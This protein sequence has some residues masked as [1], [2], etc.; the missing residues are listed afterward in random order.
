MEPNRSNN[1]NY[2]Y[3]YTINTNRIDFTKFLKVFDLYKLVNIVKNIPWEQYTYNGPSSLI[4]SGYDDNT[5][6]FTHRLVN[7]NISA[8]SNSIPYHFFGG[9]VYYILNNTY[10]EIDIYNYTD[11]TGD[12]DIRTVFPIINT[13]NLYEE[14]DTDTIYFYAY[15]SDGSFSGLVENYLTWIIDHFVSGILEEYPSNNKIFNNLVEFE[16]PDYDETEAGVIMMKR[17]IHNLKKLYVTALKERSMIKIQLSAKGKHMKDF[18]HIL[19]F[20]FVANFHDNLSADVTTGND[21]INDIELASMDNGRSSRNNITV[22]NNTNIQSINKLID[23]NINAMVDR[24][25]VV[26]TNDYIH[27]HKFYNHIGRLQ[28]LNKL[29]PILIG[30][31]IFNSSDLYGNRLIDLLAELLLFFDKDIKIL[32]KYIYKGSLLKVN[33]LL[34]SIFSNYIDIIKGDLNKSRIKSF[35][36]VHDVERWTN[37]YRA[38]RKITTIES[39][40]NYYDN[41]NKRINDEY[42]TVANNNMHR[43]QNNNATRKNIT[44]RKNNATRNVNITRKNYNNKKNKRANGGNNN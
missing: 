7:H 36:H 12:I 14:L 11:P 3:K 29:L 32:E 31:G 4:V 9:F 10:P 13:S 21:F 22:I 33:L 43:N 17:D 44:T 37:N 26:T 27:K 25:I 39:F 16:L 35:T 40:L 19:E 18:D 24:E 41:L 6:E 2:E 38:S 1:N 42:I 20:V 34:D 8:T 15:N 30:K 28:Y 5:D 23:G